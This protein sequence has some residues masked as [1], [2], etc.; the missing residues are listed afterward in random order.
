MSVVESFRNFT[1]STAVILPCSV[2]N[3]KM[4]WQ[5]RNKLLANEFTGDFVYYQFRMDILYCIRPLPHVLYPK[6]ST[7]ETDTDL[8]KTKPA[9]RCMF[10]KTI[11]LS[12]FS[13]CML[14]QCYEDSCSEI[15]LF[16][17][18]IVSCEWKGFRVGLQTIPNIACLC[19]E[20]LS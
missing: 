3:F 17:W 14:W 9:A 7:L 10:L 12:Y 1:Q 8:A 19:L 16:I 4:I 18:Q 2:Q 6:P 13:P 15:Y 20:K 11:M 5:L